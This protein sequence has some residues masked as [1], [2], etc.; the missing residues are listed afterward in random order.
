M[1]SDK[2]DLT[3]DYIVRFKDEIEI[4]DFGI[5]YGVVFNITHKLLRG[6]R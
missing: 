2:K 6:A 5:N 1:D 4:T 3:F